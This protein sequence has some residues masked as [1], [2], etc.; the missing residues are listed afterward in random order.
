MWFNR[1]YKYIC[2]RLYNFY[3]SSIVARLMFSKQK[4]LKVFLWTVSSKILARCGCTQ[5]G[6][7]I[8]RRC[9][10]STRSLIHRHCPSNSLL[11]LVSTK[12]P[13]SQP[14]PYSWLVATA[15]KNVV[16]NQ[17]FIPQCY[18]AEWKRYEEIQ[19]KIQFQLH[20]SAVRLSYVI[21]N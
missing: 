20:T 9:W 3:V 1:K 17:W 14:F 2:F 19:I 5:F 10:T 11:T 7:P 21:L 16:Q 13:T 4:K 8:F 15:V 12:S 18:I 6:F